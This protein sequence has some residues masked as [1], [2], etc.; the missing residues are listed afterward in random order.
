[1]DR[2]KKLNIYMDVVL[3]VKFAP[4]YMIGSRQRLKIKHKHL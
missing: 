1:M 4:L 2:E 3:I